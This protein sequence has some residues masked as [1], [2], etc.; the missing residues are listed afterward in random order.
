[1]KKL[2]TLALALLGFSAASQAETIDDVAV[3]K[4]SYVL[5][6]DDWDGA[7]TAKPGKGKLFGDG[8][9]LDVT[10]G[11]VATN[12][13]NIDLSDQTYCDGDYAKYAEYGKHLN[14]WRLKNAQDVIAMKVTQGSKIIILGQTH[15]S[16]YPKIA[17]NAGLTEGVKTASKNTVSE[18]G[19]FEWV[20]DNDYTIYIGSE[21]GDYYVS[22]LIVEA[23]EAEGTPSVKVS[24]QKF[25]N[26]LYFYEVTAKATQAYGQ[27]TEVYYTTD[28]TEPTSESTKYTEPI[29]CYKNGTI[30]FQAVLMGMPIPGADN[31][32]N[33]NFKFNAPTI[34][35][36]GANVTIASTYENATNKYSLNAGETLTGNT[37]TLTESATVLAYTEIKNGDY[38]TFTTNSAT[39]D[40]YVLNPIKEKKTIAITAGTAAFD[41]EASDASTKN[42][43]EAA[44][45][46]KDG[47]YTGDK[48]DFFF[49]DVEFGALPSNQ[50][51]AQYKANYATKEVEQYQVPAGQEAYIKMST[52][53]ITFLV[54]DGDSVNVKVTCSK[55][56]CKN[57]DE[58][59]ENIA[60]E[61]S[62]VTNDRKCFVNVDGTNYSHKDAEGNEAADLK[63]TADANIIEFGLAKGFHTFKK[64]SGTGNIL[65]SSIEISPVEG[66][67]NAIRE[68]KANAEK[69]N[70]M[71]NLAGQ[72]VNAAKGLVI[73]NGKK[74]VLK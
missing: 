52:T 18:N 59:D 56:S 49:K 29:K 60:A 26:G 19:R 40:V 5:V 28:G 34:T 17:E 45:I 73:M 31:E 11:T 21:G 12:K 10:G 70:V 33:V 27:E 4:H 61:G 66:G 24:E 7:G 23:N 3:C 37:F 15:A 20:A 65:I 25:E 35:A 74:V 71:F 69:A 54:A 1:M 46:I 6:F 38:A 2:F 9:F 57:I 68:F 13:Q 51:V 64:Y 36:E 30:K 63:V 44:W 8:Y 55:N 58:T 41:Q 72:R 42:P 32:A 53:N 47:A 39:Q 48:M 22:Y 62:K 43:K 50:L 14:T 67:A 16:R